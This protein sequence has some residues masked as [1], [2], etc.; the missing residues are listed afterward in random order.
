[1]VS[2]SIESSS[3]FGLVVTRDRSKEMNGGNKMKSRSKSKS[4]GPQCYQ[5]KKLGHIRRDC[6]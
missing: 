6:P 3:D 2:V 4:R 5:Y 1:M